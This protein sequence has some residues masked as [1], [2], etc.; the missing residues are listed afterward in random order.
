VRIRFKERR[1]KLIVVALGISLSA[2]L[3]LALPGAG[4]ALAAPSAA[5][6]SASTAGVVKGAAASNPCSGRSQTY[7]VRNFF[8]GPAVYPLRCGTSTWGYNHLIKHGYD[9]SSIALTVARGQQDPIFQIFTYSSNTCP[10]FEYKVV[11]NDGAL[12][13][14]GV[15]PQG[16]I[17][18]YQVTSSAASGSTRAC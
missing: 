12:N 6:G 7:I 10:N 4:N 17:T 2:A 16:I 5:A 13:G 9:P 18:A 11:Y 14:N 15:R 8:R 3:G 1:P